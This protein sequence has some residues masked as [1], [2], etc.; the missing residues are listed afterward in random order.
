MSNGVRITQQ[1]LQE[2]YELDRDIAQKQERSDHLKEGVRALLLAKQEVELGRYDARLI[3]RRV[4]H[5][6]WKQAV[7]DNLGPDF[8]EAFRKDSPSNV[9]IDVVV[10]EHAI[11]PLWNK[12][13]ESSGSEGQ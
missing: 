13:G 10:E 4:H 12:S 1:E 3:F 5:P 7:I 2:I 9:L 11:L 8:A 6:A